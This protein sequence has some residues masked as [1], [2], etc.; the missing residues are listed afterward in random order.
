MWKERGLGGQYGLRE[1]AATVGCSWEAVSE[2]ATNFE[3]KHV[4]TDTLR[5]E[6]IAAYEALVEAKGRDVVLETLRGEGK[7]QVV[8]QL[9]AG[10][11]LST[12]L[13]LANYYITPL[14]LLLISL[15]RKLPLILIS[16][17]SLPGFLSLSLSFFAGKPKTCY[18]ML[19]GAWNVTRGN[20]PPAYGV[21]THD[22]HIRLTPAVLGKAYG[23]LTHSRAATVD[24]F[25][26]L[27][28]KKRRIK[29]I[30][31]LSG[32][33]VRM[34]PQRKGGRRRQG[35]QQRSSAR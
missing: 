28:K 9:Q 35:T 26:A 20:M 17:T 34:A 6:L 4:S 5:Q 22:D 12:V 16:R 27:K 10:T 19:G 32:R 13:T 30:R 24:A 7:R 8:R 15:R 23:E 18:V 1:F 33:K 2:I 25:M 31:K 3:G 11:S 21:V 14:D 29:K